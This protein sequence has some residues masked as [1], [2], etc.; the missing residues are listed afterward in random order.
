MLARLTVDY[1]RSVVCV[2]GWRQPEDWECVLSTIRS[3]LFS[4]QSCELTLHESGDLL[5]TYLDGDP[6]GIK[7]HVAKVLQDRKEAGLN[8][9]SWWGDRGVRVAVKNLVEPD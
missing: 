5:L 2:P 7:G 4:N 3:T 6:Q 1:F 8:K 9:V